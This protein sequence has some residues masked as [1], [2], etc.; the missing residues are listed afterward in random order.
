MEVAEKA[1]IDAT[2]G[3]GLIISALSLW[4]IVFQLEE[5]LYLIHRSAQALWIL[6]IFFISHSV[7]ARFTG[8]GIR[9]LLKRD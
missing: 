5:T 9:D 4:L 2:L 1:S 8:K 3:T 6:G 7:I